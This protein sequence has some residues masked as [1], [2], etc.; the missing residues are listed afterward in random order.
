MSVLLRRIAGVTAVVLTAGLAGVPARADVVEPEPLAAPEGL[1][2]AAKGGKAKL[3]PWELR[4]R[5]AGVRRGALASLCHPAG[6]APEMLTLNLFPDLAV[7]AVADQVGRTERAD[8]VRWSGTVDGIPDSSVTLTAVGLC[9]K[10]PG[11]LALAGSAAFNGQEF[12]FRPGARGRTTVTEIDTTTAGMMERPARPKMHANL[13]AEAEAGQV[14]AAAGQAESGAGQVGAG[15]GQV[16]GAA[17][18]VGAGA[19]H[20]DASGERIAAA[21]P[22]VDALIV[23]TRGAVKAA[24]GKEQIVSWIQDAAARANKNLHASGVNATVRVVRIQAADSYKGK[25]TVEPAFNSLNSARD[26]KFDDVPGLRNKYGADIVTAVVGGYD[27]KTMVAG[28]ASYPERP[29]NPDTSGDAY[30]VVAANQLWAFILAHEWGHLFGLDHDWTN[31]PEKNP[32]FPDNHGYASTQNKF[33]TIMGYPNACKPACPYIGYFANPTLKH[34]GESL[35]VAMGKGKFTANNTRVM[36]ITA[37]ELAAYRKVKTKAKTANLKLS[38]S[39]GGGTVTPNAT[40]PYTVGDSVTVSVDPAPGHVFA[41]WTLDGRAAGKADPFTV[42]MSGD[43]TLTAK[44]AV[45]T[46]PKLRL[47]A[48]AQPTTGGE[49]SLEPGGTAFDPDT[50]VLA[51]ALPENGYD[52]A[53][54]QLD[55]HAAGDEDT[56]EVGMTHAHRLVAKFVK[57]QRLTV[58]IT[59]GVGGDVEFAGESVVAGRVNV[60]AKPRPGWTFSAW[61]VGGRK[62]STSPVANLSVS[63][64]NRITA[65]FVSAKKKPAA[66]KP[67]P[68][69]KPK[70]KPKAKAQP[71]P[72]AKAKHK[73]KKRKG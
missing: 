57:S 20:V 28:L 73:A 25:E 2:T 60:R 29:R 13:E 6:G 71:K 21:G 24:G 49:V 23:Y 8:S 36:N 41:G 9:D 72:K 37:P 34:H 30:S 26:G 43:H 1:F 47:A 32:Y 45:G 67:M 40:G 4:Q 16:D 33:V 46:E 62:V 14:G 63:G 42:S 15:A 50:K 56:L 64:A 70:P 68:K 22:V 52:F 55:G 31:S 65:Q 7:V 48:T 18:Q 54:W 51:T 44:F 17:G 59:P 66:K 27:A 11:R 19:G 35:G 12:T 3:L 53:G 39:G 5:V 69:P 10:S 58:T 61:L 38:V